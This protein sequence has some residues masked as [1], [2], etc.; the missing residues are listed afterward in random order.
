MQ[1]KYATTLQELI[2]SIDYR[3]TTLVLQLEE[4]LT[5]LNAVS[6]VSDI[7]TLNKDTIGLNYTPN[8]PGA[9]KLK[10]VKGEDPNAFISPLRMD[11]YMDANLYEP[12]ADLFNQATSALS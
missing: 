1:I 5:G 8:W 10:A 9:T 11:N 7:S 12:L 4:I 6:K 2:S 3:N